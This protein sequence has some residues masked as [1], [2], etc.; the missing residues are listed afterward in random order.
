MNIEM[1][2]AS[3]SVTPDRHPDSNLLDDSRHRLHG[4]FETRDRDAMHRGGQ[5]IALALEML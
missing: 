5:G 3:V 2:L 1:K 4:Y